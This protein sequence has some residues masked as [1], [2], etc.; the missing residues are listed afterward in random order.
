MG[1][2]HAALE[3]V[4][5]PVQPADD[6]RGDRRAAG[7]RDPARPAPAGQPLPPERD[8]A[9]QLCDLALDPA[10]GAD[11]PRPERPP[12]VAARPRRAAPSWPTSRR[13]A[14]DPTGRGAARRRRPRGAGLPRGVE[15]GAAVLACERAEAADFDRST[16]WSSGWP[17]ADDFEDYRRADIRFHIGV[18]EAA[19]LA[20]ARRPTMTEVQGQMSD[21]IA[22]IAHPEE[23]LTRSNGQ[24]RRLVVL[25]RRGDV[26]PARRG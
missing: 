5:K 8:L 11:D 9:D 10:A 16:S 7:H 23:V 17:S 26:E 15:T 3:A 6:L 13:S 24:H 18:A 21:L 1:G 12:G 4:F 20:A 25:L 22:R 19:A 2:S 14:G